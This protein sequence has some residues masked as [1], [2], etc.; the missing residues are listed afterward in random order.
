MSIFPDRFPVSVNTSSVSFSLFVITDGRTNTAAHLAGFAT[1]RVYN[2]DSQAEPR[3]AKASHMPT[4]N[5]R[6][7]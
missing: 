6:S 5:H 3:Q 7:S 1:A 4:R 2:A